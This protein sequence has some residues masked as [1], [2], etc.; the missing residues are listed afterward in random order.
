MPHSRLFKAVEDHI[1][2]SNPASAPIEIPFV[3][4]SEFVSS[5]CIYNSSWGHKFKMYPQQIGLDLQRLD[6]GE[7]SQF[8]PFFVLG[9]LQQW[10]FFGM[11]E[12]VTGYPIKWNDIVGHNKEGH[13]VVD[14]QAYQA[15]IMLWYNRLGYKYSSFML[16][17]GPGYN[18]DDP[19]QLSLE[20][21]LACLTKVRSFVTRFRSE[22]YSLCPPIGGIIHLSILMLGE[23][24]QAARDR[25]PDI[26]EHSRDNLMLF[27]STD[28][29]G[30]APILENRLLEMGWCVGEVHRLSA[31]MNVCNQYFATF[32]R[33]SKS[34]N[35]ENCTVEEC[36]ANQIT[37]P[38]LGKHATDCVYTKECQCPVIKSDIE[39][40]VEIL[41]GGGV[42][43]I[44]M[45]VNPET[46]DLHLCVLRADPTMK[47][48]AISHVWSDGLGNSEQNG[49]YRCQ[50]LHL[51]HYLDTLRK[52]TRSFKMIGRSA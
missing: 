48:T 14:P 1:P 52:A 24:L 32:L 18:D 7:F 22:I 16:L 28:S 9:I 13:M 37:G 30:P 50:L 12:E 26:I 17:A 41:K 47:Y 25:I 21:S 2:V 29:W 8:P 34:E 15:N 44:E 42:P 43:V 36:I 49:I 5:G 40:A 10:L 51:Q 38:F 46:G 27:Q 3:A 45:T 20:T 31:G 39:M 6:C 23:R 35:H 33:L 19:Y 4:T 11:L